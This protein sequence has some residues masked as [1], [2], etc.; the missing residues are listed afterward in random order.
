MSSRSKRRCSHDVSQWSMERW[1]WWCCTTSL[2]LFSWSWTFWAIG[3]DCPLLLGFS[4]PYL[5]LIAFL[6]RKYSPSRLIFPQYAWIASWRRDRLLLNT[7]CFSYAC[8][9]RQP[10]NSWRCISDKCTYR[11]HFRKQC[12]TP[13]FGRVWQWWIKRIPH[14]RWSIRLPKVPSARNCSS[15]INIIA[16]IIISQHITIYPCINCQSYVFCVYEK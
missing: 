14:F 16:Q 13:S 1:G 8:S 3:W 9:D 4:S 5:R 6:S 11:V 10:H 12:T 2:R 15:T 7:H